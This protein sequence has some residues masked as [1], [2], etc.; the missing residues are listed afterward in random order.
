MEKVFEAKTVADAIEQA[1]NAFNCTRDHMDIKVI[2]EPVRGLFGLA[3]MAKVLIR[4]TIVRDEDE[5]EEVFAG[6]KQSSRNDTSD[7][8]DRVENKS[9]GQKVLEKILD[10]M[11]IRKYRINAREEE[12]SIVLNLS[13]EAEGLLIGRHGKTRESL[14]YLINRITGT[15][16]GKERLK[17]ILDVGGYLGRHKET[18]QKIARKALK[19]VQET[20]QEEK[21]QAM[22]AFDRRIVHLALKDIPDVKTYSVGEGLLKQVVVAP[23]HADTELKQ[24]QA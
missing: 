20:K 15:E 4:P 3:K 1:E 2:Q 8:F 5:E 24:Q 17:Y 18:L 6:E 13:C 10:L 7:A 11:T 22:S 23:Q 14:Q 19:K 12:E 9:N 21:L 16:E